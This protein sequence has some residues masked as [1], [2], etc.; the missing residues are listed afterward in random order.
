VLDQSPDAKGS[1]WCTWVLGRVEVPDLNFTIVSA[2][3]DPFVVEPDAADELLVTLEDPETRSTFD[4]PQP[5]GV[6]RRSANDQIVL[7]LEACDAP[8]MTVERS[9]EFAGRGIP[10]LDRSVAG[11]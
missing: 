3:H 6:V 4:V 9:D 7:I 8:L 1:G 11:S 2:G 10:H 5:D